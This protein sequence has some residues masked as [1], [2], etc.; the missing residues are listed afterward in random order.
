VLEITGVDQKQAWVEKRFPSVEQTAAGWWSIPIPVPIPGLRY[1][2]SYVIEGDDGILVV[3]PGWDSPEAWDALVA[4]LATAGHEVTDVRGIL[5]THAHPDHFGL[6]A[7]L[8]EESGDAW[9]GMHKAEIATFPRRF[10][11][12]EQL[13]G[14]IADWWINCGIPEEEVE[15]MDAAYGSRGSIQYIEPEVRMDDGD[16]IPMAGLSM[17]AIWT[18]G[19]TPGHLCFYDEGRKVL[20]TGDHVL[21]RITPNIGIHPQQSPNPL[22]EFIDSLSN[23]GAY[24]AT[25]VYPA[26]EYRFAGIED[27]TKTLIE[28]HEHRLAELVALMEAKPASTC[29]E[30]AEGL[31]WSRSWDSIDSWAR[32]S[33]AGETASHIFMLLFQGKV[34]H[35]GGR[36]QRWSL[37]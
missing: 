25:E 21:P 3:D 32:R 24:E 33:A 36:P 8:K 9:I 37:R 13:R 31:T 4:G 35:D 17:K 30:L 19:H 27:R 5:A 15:R 29:Y 22:Y 28:H 1:V 18:P 14:Q 26:H 34:I 7:K 23:V 12:A 20:L 16:A 10:G 6:A 11:G 2:L